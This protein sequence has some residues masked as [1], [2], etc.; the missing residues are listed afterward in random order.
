MSEKPEAQRL[1]KYLSGL[2]LGSRR[3]FEALIS[4]GKIRVDGKVAQPGDHV[5]PKNKIVIDGKPVRARASDVSVSQRVILYNKAEGEICTRADPRKRPTVYRNLPRLSAQRWV[6]V[7]RL[8]INTSGL[9]LFTNDGKLANEL[10]HPSL[11]IERE[12]LCRVYGEIAAQALEKLLEG[13]EIEGHLMRFMRVR[14]HRGEGRNT[15]YSVV[16]SEGKYREVRLLWESV[17]CKVSRL[18]R[19]RYGKI[20]LPRG[21]KPGGYV[22]LSPTLIDRLVKNDVTHH[23]MAPKVSG[24]RGRRI[25]G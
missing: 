16:L 22:E 11:E 15:W 7:G 9:L 20:L 5:S 21:L 18:N 1:Q 17:G 24:D 13:V 2:G 25:R 14:R 23:A 19:I 8:D 10:M 4:E 3:K 6:S 12:Y